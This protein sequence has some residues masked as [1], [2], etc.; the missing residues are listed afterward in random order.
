MGCEGIVSKRLGS[1]YR[2]GRSPALDQ[3]E[4]SESTGSKA[5]GRGGLGTLT[6]GRCLL[7]LALVCFL[8]VVLTHIAEKL[9]VFPGMGWGLSDSPGHYLDL[10]SVM[11]GSMFLI[12]GILISFSRQRPR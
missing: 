5:R 7:L 12:A 1:T 2:R 4:K 9:H 10:A 3:S 11:L 6:L 8:I